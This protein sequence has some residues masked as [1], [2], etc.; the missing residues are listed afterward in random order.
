MLYRVSKKIVPNLVALFRNIDYHTL[1]SGI[2][3]FRVSPDLYNSFD[4]L[5]ICFHDLMNK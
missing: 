3:S 4:I 5:L 2:L 1:M